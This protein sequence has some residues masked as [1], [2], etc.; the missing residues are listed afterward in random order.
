MFDIFFPYDSHKKHD[1]HDSNMNF[2]LW[3]CMEMDR[4]NNRVAKRKLDEIE[5]LEVSV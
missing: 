3:I 1:F 4:F 2:K 5:S